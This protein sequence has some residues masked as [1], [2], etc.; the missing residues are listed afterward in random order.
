MF[1]NAIMGN[2]KQSSDRH[3]PTRNVRLNMRLATQLQ[4]LAEQNATNITVEA[5]RA[6]R[7]LLER[8][9]LWPPSADPSA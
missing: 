4:K 9:D 1:H 3:K 2:K 6:V 7:E 8:V 5:N